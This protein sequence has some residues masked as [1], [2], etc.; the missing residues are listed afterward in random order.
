VTLTMTKKT[1]NPTF[2]ETYR[3]FRKEVYGFVQSMVR[4][5]EVALDITQEAFLSFLNAH[6]QRQVSLSATPYLFQIARNLCIQHGKKQ[7]L[8]DRYAEEKALHLRAKVGALEDNQVDQEEEIDRL[9]RSL[10]KLPPQQREVVLLKHQ[11][12][13]TFDEIAEVVGA[14]RKTVASRYYYALEKLSTL[15]DGV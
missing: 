1:S 9:I 11:S 13:M 5:R 15:F 8:S 14:G 6:R 4:N 3:V 7:A 12:G 2:E 10:E